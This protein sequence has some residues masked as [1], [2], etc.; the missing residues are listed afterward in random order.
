MDSITAAE[1]VLAQSR[2]TPPFRSPSSTHRSTYLLPN[3]EGSKLD[4]VSNSLKMRGDPWLLYTSP[5]TPTS[6]CKGPATGLF[7]H[8]WDPRAVVYPRRMCRRLHSLNCEL[9][10]RFRRSP[11]PP[12][13]HCTCQQ[14]LVEITFCREGIHLALRDRSVLLSSRV[15]NRLGG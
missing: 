15:R 8:F 14:G 13:F 3:T 10:P 1:V 6:G 12:C 11:V 2:T 5:A 9:P 4:L 7:L